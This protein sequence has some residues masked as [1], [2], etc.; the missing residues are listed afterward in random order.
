MQIDLLEAQTYK[1]NVIGKRSKCNNK[2]RIQFLFRSRKPLAFGTNPYTMPTAQALWDFQTKGDSIAANKVYEEPWI[3]VWTH[4]PKLNSYILCSVCFSLFMKKTH[5]A[6][7]H[8]QFF[9]TTVFVLF[10]P[11][12]SS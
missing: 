8:L 6:V 9:D 11:N 2:T 4:I 1:S 12:I 5:N 10:Y 3:C 7:R